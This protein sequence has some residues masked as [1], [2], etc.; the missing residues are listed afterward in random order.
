[1]TLSCR[2]NW[3][4]LLRIQQND[5]MSRGKY[6]RQMRKKDSNTFITMKVPKIFIKAYGNMTSIS[7][8]KYLYV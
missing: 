1:M 2:T 8:L 7:L 5:S 6:G 3:M 4:H